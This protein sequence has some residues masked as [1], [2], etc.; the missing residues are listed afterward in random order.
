MAPRPS[1][2]LNLV[3]ILVCSLLLLHVNRLDA[4]PSKEPSEYALRVAFVFSLAKFIEWPEE[5]YPGSFLVCAVN[6]LP[7]TQTALEQYTKGN[8]LRGK[9]IEI[10]L[11][12]ANQVRANKLDRCRILYQEV[13]S[14]LA[15]SSDLPAGMV[16]IRDR[17]SSANVAPTILMWLSRS[18]GG[19][20]RFSVERAGAEATGVKFSSQLLKLATPLGE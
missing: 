19:K 11:L 10:A 20:L 18:R 6:T 4:N 17:A 3:R 14:E 16:Y 13:G 1:W 5:K 9:G 2:L 12:T 8:Q 7:E 15:F